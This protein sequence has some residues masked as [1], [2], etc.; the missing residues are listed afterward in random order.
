MIW[1]RTRMQYTQRGRGSLQL[2]RAGRIYFGAAV[3][4]LVLGW[5]LAPVLG[6]AM[7]PA[8]NV[9]PTLLRVVWFL[10]TYYAFIL[11]HRV[12]KTKGVE[13]FRIVPAE[14]GIGDP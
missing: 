5:L 11:V 10:A 2:E 12:L 14:R 6:H 1:L 9:T 13:V 7:W 3:G 8:T 4:L